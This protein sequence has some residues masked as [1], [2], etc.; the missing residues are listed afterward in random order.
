MKIDRL[1]RI[2]ER[3]REELSAALYR[4]GAGENVEVGR[5]SVVAAKVAPDLHNAVVTVSVM[6]EERDG[7]AMLSWLRSHRAEFQRHLADKVG[8]KYTPVLDFRLTDAI[9]QGARVLGILDELGLGGP[10]PGAGG[11]AEG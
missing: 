3:V 1:A 9:A 7:R 6:G 2:N 4:V 8:L 10:A 11:A 5:I